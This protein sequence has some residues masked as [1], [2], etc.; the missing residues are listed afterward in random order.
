[1]KVFTFKY[2]KKIF[3]IEIFKDIYS[4]EVSFKPKDFWIGMYLKTFKKEDQGIV[5]FEESSG[6]IISFK[7][8]IC[9][10]PCFPICITRRKWK[11]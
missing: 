7:V 5:V 4:V 6:I 1:M 3:N 8:F 2:T 11:N 10:I 9:I